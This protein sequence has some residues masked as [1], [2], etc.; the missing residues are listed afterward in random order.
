MRTVFAKPHST[1]WMLRLSNLSTILRE[2]TAV[3]SLGRIPMRDVILTAK[4]CAA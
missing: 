3:H 2:W 4:V 1:W